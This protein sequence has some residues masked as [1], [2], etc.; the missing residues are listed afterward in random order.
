MPLKR[1]VNKRGKRQRIRGA[2]VWPVG[3]WQLK[4]EF[5]GNLHKTG[6]S[7]GQLAD[8][9]GYCHF[10]QWQ[11]EEYFK[12]IT[13]EY[14]DQKMVKGRLIEEWK[15]S[16]RDNHFLDCRI[17]A[18]AIAEHVGLSRLTRD[19]WASLRKTHGPKLKSD[20]LSSAPE[21]ALAAAPLATPT[22]VQA[23]EKQVAS[24]QNGWRNRT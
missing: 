17:Y 6:L 10:G 4:G 16:R 11:G 13:A 24:K 1:S 3:T 12:Q 9:P 15:K 22:P 23:A 8:P 18:M 5:Y 2:R 14:F 20:L 21:T 7:S 19:G